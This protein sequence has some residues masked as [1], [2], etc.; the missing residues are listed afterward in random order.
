M[1]SVNDFVSRPLSWISAEILYGRCFTIVL[2][3]FHVERTIC[4]NIGTRRI[5]AAVP[6]L[7]TNKI[8]F[9]IHA[10]SPAKWKQE[11]NFRF[12]ALLPKAEYFS[13]FM[14]ITLK[15]YS[16]EWGQI[17]TIH[18]T[19]MLLNVKRNKLLILHTCVQIWRCPYH[20]FDTST[21]EW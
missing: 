4:W 17:L 13:H 11:N 9:K 21:S 14:K 15:L 12:L 8:V 16:I 2:Q 7:W 19:L 20:V 10:L 5:R 6:T 3:E 18:I 1:N